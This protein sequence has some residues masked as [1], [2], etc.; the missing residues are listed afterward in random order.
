MALSVHIASVGKLVDTLVG[1]LTVQRKG[2]CIR[3]SFGDA[4]KKCATHR[5]YHYLGK[6]C[7]SDGINTVCLSLP[8]IL[9]DRSR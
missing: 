2:V 6:L 5:S 1:H 7:I 8:Y 9:C 3:R 4:E